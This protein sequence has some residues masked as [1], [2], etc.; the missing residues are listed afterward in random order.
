MNIARFIVILV[1]TAL[2]G[3]ST[4]T[5]SKT[6]F[7]RL[8]ASH[9]HETICTFRYMG[10]QDG[11]HYFKLTSTYGARTYR[12]PQG[13]WQMGATFP[14]TKDEARWRFV[15]AHGEFLAEAPGVTFYVPQE[16]LK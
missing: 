11:F 6:A 4:P 13:D 7:Q 12:I 9:A 5:V 14:L 3:C 2:T 15:D 8:V 1:T 16:F 10:T